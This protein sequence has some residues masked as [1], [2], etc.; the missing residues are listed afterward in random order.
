M[1]KVKRLGKW[2][3]YYTLKINIKTII[4]TE[5]SSFT[6]ADAMAFVEGELVAA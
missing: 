6:F 1:Y 5:L 3:I 2:L 4:D